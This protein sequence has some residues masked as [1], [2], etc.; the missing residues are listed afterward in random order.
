MSGFGGL[1]WQKLQ[2]WRCGERS[3]PRIPQLCARNHHLQASS[4]ESVRGSQFLPFRAIY[5]GAYDTAKQFAG[6]KPSILVRFG[7]AQVSW[8][9]KHMKPCFNFCP[10]WW[11]PG[12]WPWLIPSTQ[13]AGGWW[14]W[15]GR[16]RR[17]TRWL[18]LPIDHKRA[19]QLSCNNADLGLAFLTACNC[20]YVM[21]ISHG[22]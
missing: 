12:R 16:R 17:C 10:R 15:A 6:E 3:L 18:I 13:C 1:H 11:R 7:I 22:L 14:W 2:G 9:L 21:L 5:F 20:E 4:T 8:P 19:F